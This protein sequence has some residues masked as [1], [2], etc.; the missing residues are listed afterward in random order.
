MLL[1]SDL[2]LTDKKA[3][4]YRWGIFDFVLDYYKEHNDKNLIILGDLTDA[5][6]HHSAKLVNRIVLMMRHLVESGMEIFILKGNHD[7]IDPDVPFFEFLNQISYINY[8]KHPRSWLI[9]GERC[10]F[11]PYTRNPIDEWRT[12]KQVQ[13]NKKKCS[14]VFMHQ[15]VIGSLTSNGYLMEEGLAPK[16]FDRFRGQ[17][18][19]GDIHVPQKVGPV[20]YVGSP[21]SVRFNDHFEGRAITLTSYPVTECGVSVPP[22]ELLMGEM[23]TELPGRRTID[24]YKLEDLQKADANPGDQVKVRVHVKHSISIGEIF[25]REIQEECIALDFELCSL[26]LVRDK[27]FPLR[28][29]RKIVKSKRPSE[30]VSNFS[31]RKGIDKTKQKIG[32]DLVED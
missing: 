10:L 21:Y 8:I 23:K 4:S 17:V 7:F 2:H 14:L 32:I 25:K 18:F 1:I 30:V 24:I 29:K 16:Y 22:C 31:K 19:S 6:D 11:L 13:K 12:D 20:I 5:K 28:K 3:D 9:Q 26:S 15:S 27:K